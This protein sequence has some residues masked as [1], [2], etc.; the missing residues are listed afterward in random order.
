MLICSLWTAST[1]KLPPSHRK[2]LRCEGSP[3]GFS[4]T[5]TTINSTSSSIAGQSERDTAC[6]PSMW[7]PAFIWE[8]QDTFAMGTACHLSKISHLLGQ[9][10]VTWNWRLFVTHHSQGLWDREYLKAP[11][12]EKRAGL[13]STRLLGAEEQEEQQGKGKQGF[14]ARSQFLPLGLFLVY[15]LFGQANIVHLCSLQPRGAES[16][17][18]RILACLSP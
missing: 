1:Q 11:S 5:A 8:T 6:R 14:E 13:N 16:S 17:C 10:P 4:A 12:L 7:T 18:P 2:R 9:K 15:F 3:L